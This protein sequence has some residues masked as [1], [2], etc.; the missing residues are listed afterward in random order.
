MIKFEH[1]MLVLD[2]NATVN[3][4]EAIDEFMNHVRNEETK[5]ITALIQDRRD[6]LEYDDYVSGVDIVLDYV[7]S[8]INK[9][10]GP[11]EQ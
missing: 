3:D 2:Q 7:I 5:R 10:P 1:G 11:W 8:L 4:V 6:N 9:E